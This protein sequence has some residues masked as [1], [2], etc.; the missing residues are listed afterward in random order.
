MSNKPKPVPCP[1]NEGVMC[2]HTAD[3]ENCGWN[4]EVAERRKEKIYEN[5]CGDDRSGDE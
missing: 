3:C 2:A 5:L 4:P 1:H